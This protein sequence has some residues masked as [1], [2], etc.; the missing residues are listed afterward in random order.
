MAIQEEGFVK[1]L[2]RGLVRGGGIYARARMAADQES[3]ARKK[4]MRDFAVEKA[5]LAMQG[6]IAAANGYIEILKKKIAEAQQRSATDPKGEGGEST[7][8]VEPPNREPQQATE[9]PTLEG[10]QPVEETDIKNDELQ[11]PSESNPKVEAA[12]QD[13]EKAQNSP[14][15][16]AKAYQDL[17]RAYAN[18]G[19]ISPEAQKRLDNVFNKLTNP[20]GSGKVYQNLRDV[21]SLF[22]VLENL[23]DNTGLEAKNMIGI[24]L[25]KLIGQGNASMQGQIEAYAAKR[26]ILDELFELRERLTKGSELTPQARQSAYQLAAA[27][28]QYYM[29]EAEKLKERLRADME[30]IGLLGLK[31]A[32]GEIIR[33]AD[34]DFLLSDIDFTQ[35]DLSNPV[36]E[37]SGE[38][39]QTG[40]GDKVSEKD[41]P[42]KIA[43][44][45]VDI[46]NAVVDVPIK[47]FS[48]AW[49]LDI[50]KDPLQAVRVPLISASDVDRL[51]EDLANTAIPVDEA[52]KRVEGILKG[53]K[54]EK[55]DK[56]QAH[57]DTIVNAVIS[58]MEE[59]RTQQNKE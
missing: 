58:R 48:K 10:Q 8:L 54:F 49:G 3:D 4:E 37:A 36:L 7:Q 6:D 11:L 43:E 40:E 47:A 56:G 18:L 41:A 30:S 50:S 12:T 15:A 21:K 22:Q 13:Y 2:V 23:K 14:E 59:K 19:M 33:S 26:G 45:I 31:N 1:T 35:F 55:G 53:L 24:V 25:G 42:Q 34:P 44:A 39:D 27:L 9:Q 5:K 17:N 16:K 57:I 28:Q 20:T 32:G 38:P 52:R 46:A 51:A 29:N